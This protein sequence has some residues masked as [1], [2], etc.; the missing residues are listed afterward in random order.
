M[1]LDFYR[2]FTRRRR[3]FSEFMAEKTRIL[4][5]D[6]ESAIR[7]VLQLSFP[8]EVFEFAE[9]ATGNEGVAKAAEF[10]PNLVILDLGLPDMNGIEVL[11]SLRKW[12]E[13][14]VVVLTIEDSE[15]TK[16][17]LLDAGADDYLTKPF[18]VPELQARIRVCLRHRNSM[19]A[20]PLFK[21]G[22]LEVDLNRR[23]VM[24][25]QRVI[26]LTVKEY[27][28]LSLLIRSA[29]KV[30][31][32]AQLLAGIWGEASIEQSHYLRIYIAQLRK[33]LE[34][35]PSHPVH[36]LTEPGVGYRII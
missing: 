9:A 6:D 5:I 20:T 29:G 4:I 34:T 31:P 18:G 30:V 25:D 22:N 26:K 3:S 13:V 11:K 35:N 27:E 16:V 15:R 23:H 10:H 36:I 17:A 21:S 12:T 33:R 2:F 8:A 28:L 14:P 7:N 19:E 1:H 24:I 32:Q